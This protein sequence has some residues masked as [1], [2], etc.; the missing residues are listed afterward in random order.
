MRKILSSKK[1]F[2]QVY[3]DQEWVSLSSEKCSVKI[4]APGSLGS[5]ES[6]DADSPHRGRLPKIKFTLM[7]H[8]HE[9]SP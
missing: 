3:S 6:H 7:S 1:I 9:Y 2:S 5:G 8:D 4:N